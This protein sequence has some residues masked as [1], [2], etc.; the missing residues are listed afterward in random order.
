MP[1]GPAAAAGE[2]S[3]EGS[4]VAVDPGDRGRFMAAEAVRLVWACVGDREQI[5]GNR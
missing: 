4:P 1:G 2:A 3:P 5:R